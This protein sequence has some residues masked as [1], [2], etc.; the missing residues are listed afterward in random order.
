MPSLPAKD[1]LLKILEGQSTKTDSCWLYNG[2]INDAGYGIISIGPAGDNLKWRV[3]RLSAYIFL[4]LN[5]YDDETLALH[6]IECKNK[7]C[8][9]PAHLYLGNDAQNGLDYRNSRTHCKHGH[10]LAK[11]GVLRWRDKNAVAMRLKCSECD[12]II[13]RKSHHK[14]KLGVR[15]NGN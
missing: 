1:E 14:T 6:K 2:S 10:S 12:R 7:N 3:H 15:N 4:G 11:Y 13:R 5:I 8:W 9:N